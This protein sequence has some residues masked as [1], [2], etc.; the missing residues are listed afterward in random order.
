MYSLGV[1]LTTISLKY[2]DYWIN[3]IAAIRPNFKGLLT[4][5]ALMAFAEWRNI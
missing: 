4:Y 2:P 1:E 5:G 3:L